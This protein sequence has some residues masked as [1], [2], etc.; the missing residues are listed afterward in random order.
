MKHK[1]SA[2]IKSFA[3]RKVNIPP[4]ARGNAKCCIVHVVLTLAGYKWYVGGVDFAGVGRLG[5]GSRL[6][7]LHAFPLAMLYWLQKVRNGNCDQGCK[8]KSIRKKSSLSVWRGVPL[9][10]RVT[11]HN[12]FKSEHLIMER[13][14]CDNIRNNV[15]IPPGLPHDPTVCRIYGI[16]IK[17]SVVENILNKTSHNELISSLYEIVV[18][19]NNSFGIVGCT[20]THDKNINLPFAYLGDKICAWFLWDKLHEI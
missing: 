2:R 17:D 12:N 18:L 13:K 15:P 19:K 7:D 20:G 16:K 6:W 5:I 1:A 4:E 3:K 11:L 10:K 8:G 9:H 14:V